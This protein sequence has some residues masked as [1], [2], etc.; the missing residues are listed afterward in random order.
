MIDIRL[1]CAPVAG[2]EGRRRRAGAL[3]RSAPR[4]RLGVPLAL[5]AVVV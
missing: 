1:Y 5:A 4:S 2:V 3:P